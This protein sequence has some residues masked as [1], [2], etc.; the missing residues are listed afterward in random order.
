MV[1]YFMMKRV[2]DVKVIPDEECFSQHT[3][4]VM[5]LARKNKPIQKNKVVQ[6]EK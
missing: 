4:L 6:T 1:D 5:D 3:L 2:G